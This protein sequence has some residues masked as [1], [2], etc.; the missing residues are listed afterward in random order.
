VFGCPFLNFSRSWSVMDLA[1]RR[2]IKE[3]GDGDQHLHEYANF[4]VI[5][6]HKKQLV[7]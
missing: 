3:L 5:A 7:L 4:E 2:A 6:T 1:A